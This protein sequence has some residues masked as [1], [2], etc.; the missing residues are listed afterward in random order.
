MLDRP[1][2][3]KQ[4]EPLAEVNVLIGEAVQKERIAINQKE[5]V[6]DLM[7]GAGWEVD[8][9]LEAM[10]S[11]EDFY[12]ERLGLVKL[13]SWSKGR[14]VLVGDAAYCPSVNTGMGTTSSIVGAYILAGE[15]SKH[16]KESPDGTTDLR[17]ALEAY[18]S[19]FRP[20]MQ[21]VQRGIS[22]EDLNWNMF[23]ESAFGIAVMNFLISVA[24][25]LRFDILA[26]FILREKVIDW[27]LPEYHEMLHEKK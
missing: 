20:F 6:T 7:R 22:K 13:D 9:L 1:G 25:T 12:C 16:S 17:V 11:S 10:M 5:I 2:R 23:P 15:I 26:K 4:L 14:V 24:A 27:S 19:K 18:D 3:M 21:Q 8:E